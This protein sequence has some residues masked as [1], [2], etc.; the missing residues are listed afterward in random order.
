MEAEPRSTETRT[1]GPL[2]IRGALKVAVSAGVLAWLAFYIDWA[3]F[4]A[5]MGSARLDLLVLALA[6][7]VG[8]NLAVTWRWQLLLVP[9]GIRIRYLQA[10]QSYLKGFFAAFFIPSGLTGDL[11]KALDLHD[12]QKHDPNQRGV[13]L[14]SSIFIERAFGAITV[15]IAVVLGLT[16]S[17]L[18]GADERFQSIMLAAALAVVL[19]SMGALFSDKLLVFIP[20]GMTQRFPRLD[21]FISRVRTSLQTYQARPGLLAA[22]L[23]LSVMIQILRVTAVFVIAL[24]LGADSNFVPYLIAVPVIF[25]SNMVPILGSRIGSEQ[26]LFVLFLGLAGVMPEIAMAIALLSLLLGVI[27]SLPGGYWLLRGRSARPRPLPSG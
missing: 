11:V 20:S 10:L 27:S 16:L 18:V 25:L 12:A 22:T 6:V 2:S 24:A 5:V 17:P 14:V 26:G 21:S 13:E 7:Q 15:G 19:G 1:G 3:R 8:A 9:V 23:L 4:A